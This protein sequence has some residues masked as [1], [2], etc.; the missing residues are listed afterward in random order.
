MSTLFL[1]CSRC[2]WPEYALR[3]IESVRFYLKDRNIVLNIIGYRSLILAYGMAGQ[4]HLSFKIVDEML[5]SGID[6]DV[7]VFGNLLSSCISQ[8][9][10]GFRNALK[11][12]AELMFE[13]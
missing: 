8:P 1:A 12:R 6:L 10:Y 7:I 2:A 4:L 13:Q 11:V 9:E 5:D 3:K